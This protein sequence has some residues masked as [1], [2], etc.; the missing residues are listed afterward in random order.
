MQ[1]MLKGLILSLALFIA[2]LAVSYSADFI[3]PINLGSA[4]VTESLVTIS[5]QANTTVL[6]A[7]GNRLDFEIQ[8]TTC[9][10]TTTDV[11]YAY[12]GSFTVFA[13]SATVGNRIAWAIGTGANVD[14]LYFKKPDWIIPTGAIVAEANGLGTTADGVCVA[15]VREW[16]SS[17]PY[18][19]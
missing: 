19:R 10:G 13:T 17:S 15:M 3:R 1:K 8:V 6:A 4:E 16:T 11:Y 12:D 14:L 18:L 5:S 2:P 9:A 7:N